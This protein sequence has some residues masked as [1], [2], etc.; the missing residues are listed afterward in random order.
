MLPGWLQDFSWPMPD[1]LMAGVPGFEKMATGLTKNTIKNRGVATAEELRELCVEGDVKMWV[2]QMTVDVFDSD[3]SD[4]VGDVT[5]Y[6]GATSFLPV[7]R[8]SDVCL[9][10]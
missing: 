2:C 3:H 5:D 4:F 10:M 9:F 1:L 8:K 6:V 7:A